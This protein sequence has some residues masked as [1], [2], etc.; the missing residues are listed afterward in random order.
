MDF[1]VVQPS[2]LRCIKQVPD[3]QGMSGGREVDT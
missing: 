1:L 3:N 2:H